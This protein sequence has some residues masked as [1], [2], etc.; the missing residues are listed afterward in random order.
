MSKKIEYV[1]LTTPVVRASYCQVFEAKEFENDGKPK[2][3][4]EIIWDKE[5]QQ[6]EE[7]KKIKKAIGI[8]MA[9][10]HGKEQSKWP[11]GW[12]NPLRPVTD[13]PDEQRGE[14]YQDGFLF[15]RASCNTKRKPQVIDKKSRRT[16]ES[17]EDFY[18]GCY[19]KVSIAIG[20]FNTKGNRGV[21]FILNNI[22]KVKDGD[23][24]GGA[25]DAFSDFGVDKPSDDELLNDSSDEFND[26]DGSDD[27]D[28]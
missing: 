20:Y 3:S 8:A 13:K 10:A 27:Y 25:T 5:S 15:S 4:M 14:V 11:S 28:I 7:F 9:K 12:K 23:R 18:S 24:L 2:Y 6:T 1:K 21:H 17:E 26:F 16:I 19:C 22:M